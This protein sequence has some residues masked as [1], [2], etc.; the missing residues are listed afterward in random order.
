MGSLLAPSWRGQSHGL[1]G[2]RR[3]SNWTACLGP[4]Y[5]L[6]SGPCSVQVPQRFAHH[7]HSQKLLAEGGINS[8]FYHLNIY[9]IAQNIYSS[10][11]TRCLE[12]L[13]IHYSCQVALDY[14]ICQKL[15]CKN[16]MVSV[17]MHLLLAVLFAL[18]SHYLPLFCLK[19]L[20]WGLIKNT[21]IFHSSKCEYKTRSLNWLSVWN[22]V[23]YRGLRLK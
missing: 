6:G 10:H 14:K 13:F 4:S 5:H 12:L 9:L 3:T 17:I 22:L 20:K 18:A 19:G 21:N 7:E 16:L 2:V 8:K 1:A 15:R 23:L 11:T